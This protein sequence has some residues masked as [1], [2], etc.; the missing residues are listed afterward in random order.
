MNIKI[1][2]KERKYIEN[3]LKNDETNKIKSDFYLEYLQK[4]KKISKNYQKKIILL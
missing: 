1:G 4:S 3:L 2:E